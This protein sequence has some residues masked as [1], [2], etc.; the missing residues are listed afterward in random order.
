VL[1]VTPA[2]TFKNWFIQGQAEIVA[3]ND[4][5]SPRNTTD[6]IDTDDLWVRLG[7]WGRKYNNWDIQVG[8]YEA[9]E[10][11]HFGLGLDINTLER[12]G[13]WEDTNQPPAIYGVNYAYYRPSG[14]GN[15]AAHYY[16]TDFLRVEAL[17]QY[18]NEAGLNTV[19]G[20]GAGILDFGWIKVKGGGEY[21]KQQSM[22]ED[23]KGGSDERGFGG[24]LQFVFDPWVEF[25]FNG[26][27]G[28]AD[29]LDINGNVN[30]EGSYTI[31][32]FGGFLNVRIIK[33]LLVG[34]GANYTNKWDIHEDENGDVG[35]F[36]HT[37]VYGAIQYRLFGQLYLKFVGAYAKA[38]FDQSFSEEEPYDNEM[39]SFRFRAMYLF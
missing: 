16:P 35:V 15:F 10:L 19:A 13:A 8:R 14:V 6:I 31:Y 37:Q 18:G 7:M 1:R 17:L 9:W 25:G 4:Q 24:S 23:A 26:A 12:R 27:W 20:R 33:D 29:Q 34:G 21:K 39:M 28:I 36:D 2:Y 5:Y 30:E 32:S 38:N 3:I 22:K 11:Y